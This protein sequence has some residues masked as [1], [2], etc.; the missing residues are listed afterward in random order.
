ML[1]RYSLPGSKPKWQNMM[2]FLHDEKEHEKAAVRSG[3]DL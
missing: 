3:P 2:N 1:Y